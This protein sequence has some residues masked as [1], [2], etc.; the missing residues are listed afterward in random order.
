MNHPSSNLVMKLIVQIPCHNEARTI[1]RTISDIPRRIPGVDAVEVLIIDD[2]STDDTSGAAREAGADHVIRHTQNKGLAETFRT[3]IDACLGAGADIIVNTDGDNQ[4]AGHCIPILVQ[5]ILDGEADMVIGDRQVQHSPHYSWVK[6]RVHAVG[7]SV[8]RRLSRTDVSDPVSGFRAFSRGAAA[9]LNVVSPFSYTI[10]TLIQ[11][12]TH[13]IAL[14]SVP[15]ETNPATRP[16]RLFKS[17]P[18]FVLNSLA[19]MLRIYTMYHPLRMFGYIG[20]VLGLGGLIPI[21]R[22]LYYFHSGAGAG[23][24]QSLIL[25]GVLVLMGFL[26]LLFALLADLVN[27]NRRLIESTLHK[28]RRMELD[29]GDD[30]AASLAGTR[31]AIAARG[32]RPRKTDTDAVPSQRRRG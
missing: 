20:I 25:G 12:G 21:V 5:P 13:Q 30:A 22:F 26:A 32:P 16:S 4:Y 2:G 31:S 19:T 29:G 11:A 7:T 14:T 15:I 27:F 17:I 1:A 8:V 10:E 23:H 24:I 6:K 9:L 28:V 3:G 18:H